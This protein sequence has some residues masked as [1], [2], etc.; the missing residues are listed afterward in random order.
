MTP[1][2]KFLALALATLGAAPAFAAD[3]S[4]D[5]DRVVVTATRVPGA[6]ANAAQDLSIVRRDRIEQSAGASL[7]DLLNRE[8]GVEVTTNGGASS[9]TGIYIRG[10]KPAQS[11]VLI[12]GFRLTNPTD[13]SAPIQEIPLSMLDRAE[14][15]R[16]GSS[17]LYGS[18]AIGGVV[19]L[20]TRS[21]D[22][23]P[24]LDAAVTYG[25][26]GTYRS[27]L[28]YGGQQ[29]K[30]Q[31]YIAVGAD[32]SEGFSAASPKSGFYEQDKD[33]YNR[34][35]VVA[36]LKQDLDNGHAIKFNFLTINGN[37]G[38]DLGTNGSPTQKSHTSLLGGTYE[39]Q[40][41]QIW[42]SDFKLGQVKYDYD[43]RNAGFAYGPTTRS[44]QAAWLNYFTLPVGK[45]TLGFEYEEQKINEPNTPYLKTVRRIESV[46]SQ[47]LGNY[48]AN[49]I[50]ANLRSD[51]WTD[52]GAQTTGAL[53]YAY[54]LTK[55]WALTASAATAF[56]APTFDDLY[57]PGGS[58][59]NLRPEKSR[60]AEI[61]TRYKVNGD[62]LRLVAFRNR[63]QDAIEL[64][65]F[66]IPQNVDALITGYTLS[67]QH[68]SADWRWN[69]AYT[70][71]TPTNL[72]TDTQLARR[73]RNIFTASLERELGPWRLGGEFRSEDQRY[74]TASITSGTRMGGYGLLGAYASYALTPNQSVQV[75]VENALD[76]QYETVQHFNTPGRSLF[77]TWRYNPR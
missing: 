44:T 69:I 76:K 28:G 42:R 74:D 50:Q 51:H 75:R 5:D 39:A 70:H 22:R 9:T 11:A 54:D 40:W 77:V 2:H 33:G 52:Y 64:D 32:G 31:F 73:G 7:G 4:A 67:W 43:Y 20:F 49:H 46:Y 72:L 62:V 13:G 57:Y 16:G 68:A 21:P 55:Q 36:K 8:A 17:G 12:D 48:G 19:Q 1:Q 53:L 47:W 24:A 65:A 15:I 41:N 27:E 71:Q 25:R 6:A 66:W 60:S 26:Y 37:T 38:V 30:T 23:A 14:V 3:S 35:S 58:N 63:I 45:A 59:P 29:N 56:R 61:G 18:G 10:T 34:T